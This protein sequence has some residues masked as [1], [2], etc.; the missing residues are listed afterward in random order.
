MKFSGL[1]M[2]MA[3][4]V[5]AGVLAGCGNAQTSTDEKNTSGSNTT[6]KTTALQNY[7]VLLQRLDQLLFNL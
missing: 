7:L 4:L 5:I 1:K 6:D 2:S 3:G